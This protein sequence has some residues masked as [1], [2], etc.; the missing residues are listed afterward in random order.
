MGF[1]ANKIEQF[2]LNTIIIESFRKNNTSI[3][4]YNL[5]PYEKYRAVQNFNCRR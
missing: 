5:Y 4:R 1:N 3:N 2:A